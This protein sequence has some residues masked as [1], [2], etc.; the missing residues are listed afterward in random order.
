MLMLTACK[1]VY[2]QNQAIHV[3]ADV[4]VRFGNYKKAIELFTEIIN[5]NSKDY[6]ALYKR[7]YCYFNIKDYKNSKIDSKHLLKILPK[8]D[9]YNWYRGNTYWNYSNCESASGNKRKSLKL[10]KKA[11]KYYESSLL[12]STIGYKQVDMG[13]YKEAI[14]NLDEAIRLNKGNAYAYSNR[15]WAYL[16]L[17]EYLLARADITVSLLLDPK[18][19]Y[20]YKHSALIYVAM[21]QMKLACEHFKKAIELSKSNYYIE[22]GLRSLEDLY[23]KYCNTK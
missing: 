11:V 19:P 4:E 3:E 14:E 20:A 8:G 1:F 2:C 17:N 13:F 15:A 12:Y 18:N 7:S 16:N 21:N 5:E 10:I 22:T 6:Y 23:C 9:K